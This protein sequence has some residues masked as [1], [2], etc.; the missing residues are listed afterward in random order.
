MYISQ[1]LVGKSIAFIGTHVPRHCG[2]ATFTADLAGALEAQYPLTR[3]TTLAI[4]DGDNQYDYPSSVDFEL[5]DNLP[6]SYH[7]AAKHIEES[8]VDLVCLQHEF[9]IFGGSAGDN[10]LDLLDAIKVPVITTLHTVL[11][12]PNDEERRVLMAIARR[13]TKL[14]VMSQKAVE[15]LLSVYGIPSGQIELIPHGIPAMPNGDRRLSKE[16]LGLVGRRVLLTF[17]LISSD[18]GLENVVEAL[19]EVVAA[20]PDTLYV[21]VGQT[22]PKVKEQV[23]ETYRNRLLARIAELDLE[24]N[25]RFVDQ[26]VTLDDLMLYLSAADIYVTPY[27]KEEQV[28]SGTLAIAVGSGRATISTPYWHAQEMLQ[29]NRG[30]LV[31]FRDPL[32]IARACLRL[33]YDP[34]EHSAMER[35]AGEFGESVQWPRIAKRYMRTFETAIEAGDDDATARVAVSPGNG[36]TLI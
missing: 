7:A 30:I 36:P 8:G 5:R 29:F 15:L 24:N 17:G 2:I 16:K 10:I 23:G 11:R 33:F 3:V 19:P 9:G 14:V 1:N 31:P 12:K 6:E 35:R 34:Q 20:F 4:S 32:S 18:K 21:V 26:Y 27:L 22:H 28:T 25:V 13:S